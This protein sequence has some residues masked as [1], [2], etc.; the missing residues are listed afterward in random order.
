[1]KKKSTRTD[2]QS[3]FNRKLAARHETLRVLRPLSHDELGDGKIM[4]GDSSVLCQTVET[5]ARR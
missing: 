2:S 4:A 5:I 3:T 1:M